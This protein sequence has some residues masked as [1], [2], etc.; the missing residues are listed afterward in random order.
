[1]SRTS[2]FRRR[3][4]TVASTSAAG[5]AFAGRAHAAVCAIINGRADEVIEQGG[6]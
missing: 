6:I 2:I 4:L 5:A 3:L 1:M